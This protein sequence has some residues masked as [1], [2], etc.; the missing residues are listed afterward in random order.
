[1]SIKAN[2]SLHKC[3][4]PNKDFDLLSGHTITVNDATQRLNM[5]TNIK[6]T[7]KQPLNAYSY[8]IS[9]MQP[10]V[11]KRKT[12]L[13]SIRACRFLIMV[14]ILALLLGY[15]II[16]TLNVVHDTPFVTTKFKPVDSLSLPTLIINYAFNFNI[17]CFFV[18]SKYL[19]IHAHLNLLLKQEN[20]INV[21]TLFIILLN[22]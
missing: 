16:L 9:N 10:L 20:L 8:C 21:L 18:Y 7:N 12:E 17:T 13:P 15:A 5:I 11:K 6:E 4:Q 14:I 22:T 2:Y 1:M 19:N 3:D